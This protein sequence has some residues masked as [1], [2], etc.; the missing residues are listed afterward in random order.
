M[1]LFLIFGFLS[2]M[3]M[4]DIF[5]TISL[6]IPNLLLARLITDDTSRLRARQIWT[7]E[8]NYGM[9]SHRGYLLF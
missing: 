5:N 9:S 4:I 3:K 1:Y 8:F 2:T 7:R 6:S